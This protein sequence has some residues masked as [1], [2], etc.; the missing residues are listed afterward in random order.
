LDFITIEIGNIL[1][2][3]PKLTDNN[4]DSCFFSFESTNYIYKF[5]L[6]FSEQP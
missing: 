6:V 5:D 4:N 1:K 3:E 2:L